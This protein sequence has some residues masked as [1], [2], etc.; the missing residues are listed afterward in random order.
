MA[1]HPCTFN[2]T[3]LLQ[4]ANKSST[5]GAVTWM[6]PLISISDS[7][8]RRVAMPCSP[9]SVNNGRFPTFKLVS[10]GV[11]SMRIPRSDNCRQADM[12][13]EMRLGRSER[14]ARAS[15]V[16]RPQPAKA[17]TCIRLLVTVR[18]VTALSVSSGQPL[19]SNVRSCPQRSAM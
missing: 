16:R 15:S 13:N 2:E 6:A 11:S 8:D 3:R 14:E 18:D 7:P 9:W 1:V 12:S 19:S 10:K 17:K 4:P 5:P